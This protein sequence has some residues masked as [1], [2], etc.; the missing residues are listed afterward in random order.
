MVEKATAS[1]NSISHTFLFS[2]DGDSSLLR[3]F[4]KSFVYDARA[5]GRWYGY[6]L[7]GGGFCARR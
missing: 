7:I 3:L 1:F 2:D 6:S 5:Q 4:G